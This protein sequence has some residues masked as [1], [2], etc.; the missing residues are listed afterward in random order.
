LCSMYC[1]YMNLIDELD[2]FL[3]HV[4]LCSSSSIFEAS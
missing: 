2:G 1:R 3:Y 4:F